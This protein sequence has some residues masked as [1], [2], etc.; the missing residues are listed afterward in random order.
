MSRQTELLLAIA[1][2]SAAGG[3]ARYLLTDAVQLRVSSTFPFGTLV[4]NVLGCFVLG[5][6]THMVL[7]TG[8]FSP[9]TRARTAS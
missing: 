2:G 3:V 6:I 5:F 9:S 8:E 1:V 7:E 4:V